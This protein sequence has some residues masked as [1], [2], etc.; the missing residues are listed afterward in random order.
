MVPW[1]TVLSLN[2]SFCQSQQ[3]P[4]QGRG[5]A[6]EQARQLWDQ[7]SARRMTLPEAIELCRKC[8]DMSP[9][10][11]N[12]GNTFAG[13]ARKMM[14]DWLQSLPPVEGQIAKTTVG[15]YVVGQIE[16]KELLDV[17]NHFAAK[18]KINGVERPMEIPVSRIPTSTEARASSSPV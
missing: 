5:N 14:E 1:E 11:F 17:L 12:N 18:W 9:F 2:E 6:L 3:T 8:F 16:R 7:S 13:A 4:S 10:V 15:H